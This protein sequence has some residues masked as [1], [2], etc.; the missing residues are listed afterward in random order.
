MLAAWYVPPTNGDAI[1]VRHRSGS[2]RSA[3]IEHLAFLAEARGT[4][5]ANERHR[6]HVG[7]SVKTADRHIQNAYGKIAISTRVAAALFAM[8]HGLVAWGE[9]PIA[10]PGAKS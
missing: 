1:I 9:I 5:L 7:I 6:S 4:R 3:T 8:Q 10:R 2:T